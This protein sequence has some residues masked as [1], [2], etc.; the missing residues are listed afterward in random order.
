M[1]ALAV[2]DLR[3]SFLAVKI[4]SMSNDLQTPEPGQSKGPKQ[5]PRDALHGESRRSAGPRELREAHAG[6]PLGVGARR[7]AGAKRQSSPKVSSG[8]WRRCSTSD[9][10]TRPSSRTS[11][12]TSPANLTH[13]LDNLIRDGYV[14][15]R[16]DVA[17]GRRRIV[18]LA[19]RGRRLAKRLMPL[20]VARI[21]EVMGGLSPREQDQLGRLCRKLGY[22]A[23]EMS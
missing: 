12:L 23:K 4:V 5:R 22:W 11:C 20:H 6:R 3:G 9:R 8:F 21:V 18:H 14:E 7:A 1:R 19:P 2:A 17:D 13:V 16:R 10:W 15:R